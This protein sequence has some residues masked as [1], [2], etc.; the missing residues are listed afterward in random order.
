MQQRFACRRQCHSV[1]VSFEQRDL[2][3]LLEIVHALADCGRRYCLSL[4]RSRQITFFANC[5]EQLQGCEV[6]TSNEVNLIGQ[7]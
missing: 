1:W 5:D 4:R 6:N 2:K 3:R 7:V